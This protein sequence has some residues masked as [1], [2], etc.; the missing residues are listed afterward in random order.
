[1]IARCVLRI[2]ASITVSIVALAA[3][4]ERWVGQIWGETLLDQGFVKRKVWW[5]IVD[6]V[7]SLRSWLDELIC[8]CGV[9]AMDLRVRKSGLTWLIAKILTRSR[10][11][12]QYITSTGDWQAITARNATIRRRCGEFLW[13]W[14]V[15][16]FRSIGPCSIACL[17]V[18]LTIVV[19][20]DAIRALL[21]QEVD[22]VFEISI[23]RCATNFPL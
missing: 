6:E 2:R 10:V 4:F 19:S 21:L 12:A 5:Q 23:K 7:R 8:S 18:F 22:L 17:V 3:T 13:A 15:K 9:W 11:R 16:F 1:M 14:R 20:Y